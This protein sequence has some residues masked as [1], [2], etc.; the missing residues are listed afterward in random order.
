MPSAPSRG[1]PA[2]AE[3]Q[4]ALD[5]K[6]HKPAARYLSEKFE[7]LLLLNLSPF[8]TS[9]ATDGPQTGLFCPG[10]STEQFDFL[11]LGKKE[12]LLPSQ[13]SP[14]KLKVIEFLNIAGFDDEEL[15]FPYVIA[16]GLDTGSQLI[17]LGEDGL[18]KLN[19][20]LDQ[21]EIQDSGD[22]KSKV[23]KPNDQGIRVV[24]KLYRLYLGSREERISPVKASL[25]TRI[26]SIL[27]KS[28]LAINADVASPTAI[29][30]VIEDG[31]L[32][33]N[34]EFNV[35]FR[36]AVFSFIVHLTRLGS[37]GLIEEIGSNI[38]ESI[39]LW[40]YADGWPR[41]DNAQSNLTMNQLRSQGYISIGL[42]CRRE[43]SIVTMNDLQI[44][45][46]LLS[47][48]RG[49]QKELSSSAQEA[50]SSLLP[51]FSS[52]NSSQRNEVKN[53]VLQSM[54][55]DK[56]MTGWSSY[57]KIA[58]RAL[59]F[60]DPTRIWMCLLASVT[61]DIDLPDHSKDL[62]ED[63]RKALHP[64]W[65]KILSPKLHLVKNATQ[66]DQTETETDENADQMD[67]DE[68]S[69]LDQYAIPDFGELLESLVSISDQMPRAF[70]ITTS[71]HKKLHGIPIVIL[72]QVVSLLRS[73]LLLD[74]M[75]STTQNTSLE[76]NGGPDEALTVDGDWEDKISSALATSDS[77]RSTVHNYIKSHTGTE[78]FFTLL[79]D[80]LFHGSISSG[81]SGDVLLEFF[82]LLPTSIIQTLVMKA[83]Q[84]QWLD[85]GR[86]VWSSKQSERE[87]GAYLLGTLRALDTTAITDD[88]EE[89][90]ETIHVERILGWESC[91]AQV[92][93][94][95]PYFEY[96]NRTDYL[97]GIEQDSWIYASD[98]KFSCPSEYG[99]RRH[100]EVRY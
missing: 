62:V 92:F 3:Y 82:P 67:I 16:A 69:V 4:K 78:E 49:E 83:R 73:I 17:N 20:N 86:L 41:S 19:I 80:A 24:K 90:W 99:C 57:L 70:D 2:A 79:L 58:N 31:L 77:I 38:V 75:K 37:E 54:I 39:R 51:C 71:P 72:P 12:T 100:A 13:L 15:Y 68:E 29:R 34:P 76:S 96:M 56:D 14:L 65:F 94:I 59:S 88:V 50:I 46:F 10:L 53:L 42:L 36:T 47:A 33:A 52:I 55:E 7:T 26:L 6:N 21:K 74:A 32:G 11:T 5:L 28:L 87:I 91:T 95:L 1:T 64:Y 40:I 22:T 66:K 23:T 8:Q 89:S 61:A 98:I 43:S 45:R 84:N 9:P 30:S 63:G 85:L 44:L 48:V 81:S 18:K 60:Q 93:L 35:K 97:I 25:K 27:S